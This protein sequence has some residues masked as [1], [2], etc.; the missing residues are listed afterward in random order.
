MR[1]IERKTTED[2]SVKYFLTKK[3]KTCSPSLKSSFE[4]SEMVDEICSG[5][6]CTYV[7]QTCRYVTTRMT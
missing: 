7:S 3:M 4:K 2:I 5:C 1:A 6:E